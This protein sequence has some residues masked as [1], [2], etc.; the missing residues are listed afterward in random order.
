MYLNIIGKFDGTKIKLLRRPAWSF[1]LILAKKK[2]EKEN[3]HSNS[4]NIPA[5]K[6][7]LNAFKRKLFLECLHIS[8]RNLDAKVLNKILAEEAL[9]V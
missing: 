9:G 1:Q 5:L 3:S 7:E 8:P 2:K 4:K 6:I